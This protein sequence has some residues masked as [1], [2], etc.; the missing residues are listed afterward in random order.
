[1][2]FPVI[3]GLSLVFIS[4]INHVAH[5][6]EMAA[7]REQI[8]IKAIAFGDKRGFAVATWQCFH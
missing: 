3:V 8:E 7:A 4:S 6:M 2:K 5:A 1:M